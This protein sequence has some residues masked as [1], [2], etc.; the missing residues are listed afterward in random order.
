MFHSK[1]ITL[2]LAVIGAVLV[3]SLGLST[4]A[5]QDSG[6]VT[7]DSTL[8]TLL[9]VAEH[10]YGYSPMTDVSNIDKGQF[11]PLFDSMMA[12]SDQMDM[13]EEPQMDMTEEVD[14]TMTDEAGMMTH[15]EP[16]VVADE[17]V[18]CTSLGVE[19]EQYLFDHFQSDMMMS[20]GS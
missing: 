18:V 14:M 8:I 20:D 6:M 5:A 15:L 4:V 12:M 13:T 9:Y 10:D 3:M 19:L 11:T 17:N 1:R 16:G 7:C 2:V